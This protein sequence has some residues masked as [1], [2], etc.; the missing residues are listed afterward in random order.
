MLHQV[1][2]VGAGDGK[3]GE[4]EEAAAAGRRTA[5]AEAVVLTAAVERSYD[6]L[7]VAVDVPARI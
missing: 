6:A 2:F 5:V 4:A 3:G 7:P 1:D